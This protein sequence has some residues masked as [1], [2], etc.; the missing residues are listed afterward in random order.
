MS[1]YLLSVYI[2]P[3]FEG[4]MI[5]LRI[6][7]QI[8]QKKA[9]ARTYILYVVTY[10]DCPITILAPE[11][12]VLILPASPPSTPNGQ[13]SHLSWHLLMFVPGTSGSTRAY[14]LLSGFSLLPSHPSDVKACIQGIIMQV[15]HNSTQIKGTSINTNTIQTEVTLLD[16]S[17]EERFRT[18]CVNRLR[19]PLSMKTFA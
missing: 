4:L 6:H 19:E 17:E 16:S 15:C 3:H 14:S 9:A 2:A 7:A 5:L 13:G 18:I 1:S 10:F 11:T 12:Q 8:V